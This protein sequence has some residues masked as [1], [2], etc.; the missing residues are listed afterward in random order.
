MHVGHI[1]STVIGDALCRVLRFLG[2]TVISD[3]HIGDWGTQ[4]GMILYGYKNFLDAEAYRRNP[5]E[6]LARLYRQVRKLS[7]KRKNPCRTSR[8]DIEVIFRENRKASAGPVEAAVLAE[9]AKLHAGNAEN[10]R[11]W[12][13]FLPCCEDEIRRMYRRLGVTFDH[14]LG[15][16]F[17][18]D[19]LPAIVEEL[20]G[21]KIACESDGAVCIFID[22]I[23]T[24]MLVRKKDG[25]F[26][27]GTTDLAT[28][29]YRMDEWRPDA[30]LYVVDHR[31]SLHFKQLF[32][33]ARRLGYGIVELQHV[34]FG[35]VL[36]TT[37]GPSRPLAAIPSGWRACST[38]R[39]AGRS[40]SFRQ[41]TTPSPT[42]PSFPRS[43]AGRS[44]SAW[45]R[46]PEIRRPLAE[47]H[48]R[49]RVQ[50]RQDVGDVGQYGHV[51][52]IC[53]R[54]RAKHLLEGQR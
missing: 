10:R 25:A 21:R 38:R 18:E 33:A 51:H 49:L 17:Y 24:P 9:T 30:I 45:H 23:E 53:L 8:N 28:I 32:A 52:A 3:N 54:P 34:S 15:E 43:S 16:S 22:G 37:A 11:L 1:R 46:R 35:T 48:Q 29:R 40:R 5:V 42:A 47:P 50:L 44:P 41:T 39:C 27:Y 20:L 12:A 2:H 36:G 14:T 6:E 7:M 19:R 13:E 4:F 26:L 31:Q